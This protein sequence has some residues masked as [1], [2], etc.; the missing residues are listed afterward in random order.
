VLDTTVNTKDVVSDGVLVAPGY[1]PVIIT[2]TATNA[3]LGYTI[4]EA[5]VI[6]TNTKKSLDTSVSTAQDSIFQ[7]NIVI[8]EEAVDPV[9]E[10]QIATKLRAEGNNL[11]IILSSIIILALIILAFACRYIV[12]LHR[13]QSIDAEVIKKMK[14]NEE[15][16]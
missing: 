4:I 8:T 10:Q 3:K 9:K 11:T 6:A 7:P 12:M 14:Q 2:P 15:W 16:E 1:K 13:K 5:P